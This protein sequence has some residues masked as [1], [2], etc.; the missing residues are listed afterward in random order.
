MYL[1]MVVNL[2]FIY[3]VLQHLFLQ[4][5][6]HILVLLYQH[7]R[8]WE[9][10]VLLLLFHYTDYQWIYHGY[11]WLITVPQITVPQ[12][13]SWFFDLDFIK[14]VELHLQPP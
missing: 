2:S 13:L 6:L 12:E 4:F 10:F 1:Q 8:H 11:Y 5:G 14:I 9:L 7:W 3:F